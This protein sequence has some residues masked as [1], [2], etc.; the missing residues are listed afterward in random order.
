MRDVFVVGTGLIPFGKYPHKTLAEIGWPA[1]KE[2]IIESE[3]S[4]QSIDAVYCG[5]ALGGMLTGQRVMKTL[6]I[7]GMPIINIENACSSS[8]SALAEAWTA[9]ASGRHDVALVIGV[10]KLTKF[11]GGTLP[12][13]REDWEVNQGM[14]MP[15]LYAMR[16][17]RYMHE[18][19][20]TD[21]QLAQVAVKAHE[22]GSLNPNAQIR[23]K[24]T[25]EEVM[26][27]RPVAD[28]FTLWH[29]CP[30]GDGAA[31]IIVASGDVARKG[32]TKS[33][34]IVASEVT[35][36]KYTNGYRDMTW[37]ELTAR[38]AAEAYEMAGIAPEDIDVAEIHD[39]F[40]IAELMYYEAF[41]FCERGG[42]YE[43]LASGATSLGGH[44]CVNPSGGLLSRGHPVGATGAAQ[45]VEIVR[46]LE[47]RAG[48]HQ[49]EGAKVGVTHA[50]GGGISGFDHGA[51][52]IH[53]F[54]R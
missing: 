52:S 12:L 10:E 47:G 45:A 20:L 30:T 36:G 40:T 50:T 48:S 49:V 11:G 1:V 18:Y 51:C 14:V 16:A 2:A 17:R 41:S 22:H 43:L 25:I 35:S 33:V 53:I 54:S 19:G 23:K 42:A 38:G 26:A 5:S 39:A 6:G 31:A 34:R 32:R 3:L 28:P 8:S 29:C 13:E 9:V 7:T 21:Q 15:A 4:P 24:V 27:S 46:Q 37:A 44:V